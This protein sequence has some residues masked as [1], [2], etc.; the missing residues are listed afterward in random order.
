MVPSNSKARS[1]VER[2][3]KGI[4]DKPA[5]G[6]RGKKDKKMP[7]QDG[8]EIGENAAEGDELEGTNTDPRSK[9]M[10]DKPA[11]GDRRS[12][13]K[14]TS[15]ENEEDIEAQESEGGKRK[16]KRPSDWWAVDSSSLESPAQEGKQGA[17]ASL[18]E[19]GIKEKAAAGNRER[20]QKK[21][22]ENDED[23]LD[24]GRETLKPTR[25]GRKSLEDKQ[26]ELKTAG[27]NAAKKRARPTT[28]LVE[29]PEVP[30]VLAEDRSAPKK[31]GW[32][33]KRSGKENQAPV[34]ETA[35]GATP[36]RRS[37][38]SNTEA[39][40]QAAA[41]PSSRDK[42]GKQNRRRSAE[43]QT[44][45]PTASDGTKRMATRQSDADISVQAAC[46]KLSRNRPR[47]NK[48]VK[49]TV[50]GK[51]AASNS[52]AVQESRKNK[53]RIRQSNDTP[54]N[55]GPASQAPRKKLRHSSQIDAGSRKLKEVE[56]K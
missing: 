36:L 7:A 13:Q 54:K 5:A 40:L 1:R 31:R 41:A 39:E 30:G 52:P 3:E 33:A 9:G 43:E 34:D 18:R 37:R 12:K 55:S 46:S 32:L 38:P 28:S 8:K 19:R 23:E 53:K 6:N 35:A 15:V 29:E 16:R 2:N 47:A 27:Q 10:K 42:D 48:G 4:Q 56:S 44:A 51:E 45:I 21:A 14:Q 22:N 25:R 11:A 17:D 49:P 26:T 20:K 24:G 50:T